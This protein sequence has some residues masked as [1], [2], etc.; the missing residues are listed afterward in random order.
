MI[1]IELLLLSLKSE[2][3][4][5]ITTFTSLHE[6]PHTGNGRAFVDTKNMQQ[7]ISPSNCEIAQIKSK[8]V[9]D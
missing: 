7:I 1:V 2:E 5:K 4:L 9:N 8:N 3:W 6:H